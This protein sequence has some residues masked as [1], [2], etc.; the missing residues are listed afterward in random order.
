MKLNC[1]TETKPRK[2]VTQDTP[3][4]CWEFRPMLHIFAFFY[5]T[6]MKNFENTFVDNFSIKLAL[7]D[8]SK[9][10]NLCKFKLKGK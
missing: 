4:T 1:I 5:I 7:A 10:Y 9:H 2:A 6:D 3:K 8:L